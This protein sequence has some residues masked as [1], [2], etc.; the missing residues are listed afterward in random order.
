[1]L[2]IITSQITQPHNLTRSIHEKHIHTQTPPSL[3]IPPIKNKAKLLKI[4]K[5]LINES[6]TTHKKKHNDNI[7]SRVHIVVFT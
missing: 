2:L 4:P 1:M 5:E 7:C 3:L 6:E